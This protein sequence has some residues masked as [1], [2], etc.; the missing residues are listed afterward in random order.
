MRIVFFV[1]IMCFYL[2]LSAQQ[3][4]TGEIPPSGIDLQGAAFNEKADAEYMISGVPA[5]LWRYGCGPTAL[6]M[7]LGYYDIQGYSDIFPG[8]ASTQ[9]VLV[10]Q[11]IASSANYNDYC[12]PLDYYPDLLPDLSE[13]PA[14]DEHSNN[15]IADF[16]FTSRSYYSNYYGWSWGSDIAGAFNN[17]L[18]YISSYSGSCNTQYL[19]SFSFAAFMNEMNGNRP[20]MALVDTDG[21]GYT[22]HFITLMGY[23]QQSG[24]NYYGCYQT[25]DQT[26]HW[27]EW[28]EIIPGQ[29][30]GIY[31]V[32]TF[33][34]IPLSIEDNSS[35]HLSVFPDPASTEIFV[36]TP[37][38]N[39][40]VYDIS[41]AQILSGITGD[42]GRVDVSALSSGMYFIRIISENGEKSGKF[43]VE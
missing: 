31:C 5:Y 17:Y 20:M 3:N 1:F 10:N 37:G 38:A 14:G 42:A 19:T 36:D 6:G 30:W 13:L 9:T 18:A 24:V 7:V 25:W 40:S 43:I 11:N 26:V 41:G 12:L 23:R 4:T 2:G 39:V 34:L 15:S 27:Y 35:H 22:D 33:E 28:K 16:M 8:D 21:D 32:Y 29:P